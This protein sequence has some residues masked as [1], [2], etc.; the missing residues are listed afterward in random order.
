MDALD[1]DVMLA[2]VDLHRSVVQLKARRLFLR[3]E[4]EPSRKQPISSEEGVTRTAAGILMLASYRN[5]CVHIFI[6]PAMLATALSVTKS[7]Q[8]GEKKRLF[9]GC[10]FFDF[11]RLFLIPP[12]NPRSTVCLFFLPAG[13]PLQ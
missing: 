7:S 11:T 9:L 3:R 10:F 6:R 13:R 5:Q 8:R 12:P 4:E 1:S 2:A